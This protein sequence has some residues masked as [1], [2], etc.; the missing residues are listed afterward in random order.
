MKQE[1]VLL[2]VCGFKVYRYQRWVYAS[3]R[4]NEATISAYAQADERAVVNILTE[5]VVRARCAVWACVERLC[6]DSFET[7]SQRI[8]EPRL[9]VGE[10][11]VMSQD[12]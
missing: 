12:L 6:F 4:V 3:V 8:V 5:L 7:M 11:F 2:L 1:V 10:S 9:M